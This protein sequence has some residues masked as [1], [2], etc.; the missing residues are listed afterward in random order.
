VKGRVLERED[1]A[2]NYVKRIGT[3]SVYLEVRVSL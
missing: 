3:R 1:R 2:Q